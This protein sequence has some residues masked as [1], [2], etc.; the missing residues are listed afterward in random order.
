MVPTAEK[1]LPSVPEE[2]SPTLMIEGVFGVLTP[3]VGATEGRDIEEEE[4]VPS[5]TP[6]KDD[7]EGNEANDEDQIN[8][9]LN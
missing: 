3:E 8:N 6:G 7:N 4:E 2:Q 9:A 5:S 1:A